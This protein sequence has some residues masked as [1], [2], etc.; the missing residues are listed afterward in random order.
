MSNILL[1]GMT[2]PQASVRLGDRNTTFAGLIR[3]ALEEQGHTVTWTP[4]S[5]EW[6]AEHLSQYDT[7]LVGV[8]PVTSLSANYAY[9]A[10]AVLHRLW[11]DPRL[12]LF[13]DAP[14]VRQIQ[15]SLQAAVSNEHSL[16][17]PFYKAR[18]EYQ[19]VSDSAEFMTYVWGACRALLAEQWPVTLY[20][21][22]PW[23]NL[24][25]EL[26]KVLP[27]GAR[28][29]LEP[30]NLDSLIRVDSAEVAAPT[31]HRWVVDA[32]QTQW[33]KSNIST[34]TVPAAPM[35]WHKGWT[36]LQVRWQLTAAVGALISPQKT[37]GT[38]WSPYYIQ[39]LKLG[40]P[41]A[42]YWQDSV[43][44]GQ[45]WSLLAASIEV[46]DAEARQGL[47]DAQ[48]ALYSNNIPTAEQAVERL[49]AL[50]DLENG[51]TDK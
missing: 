42:T 48:L 14:D 33:A 5:V 51:E 4:A 15:T 12:R 1:T 50:L 17:K 25:S 11:D 6:D 44:L 9:G 34:L 45:P 35:K 18:R 23:N 8:A 26:E 28:G 3:T 40:V 10:L 27:E 37:G 41:V 7:V 30:L 21:E 39:A 16:F 38:W 2:G 47:A 43:R 13:I 32:F 49:A 31:D 46:L 20:P 22:L 29:R 36:D 19:V 24:V